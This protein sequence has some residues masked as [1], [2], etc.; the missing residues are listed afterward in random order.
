M[1]KLLKNTFACAITTAGLIQATS[2]HAD[3]NNDQYLGIQAA[4]AN[5]TNH[6]NLS[7]GVS[8]VGTYGVVIPQVH[9][10]FSAELEYTQSVTNPEHNSAASHSEFE[11]YTVA[12][13][14]VMTVPISERISLRGRAGALYENW[15]Y[16]NNLTGTQK[17]SNTDLSIG[18]GAIYKLNADMNLIAEVTIIESD[19]VHASAG[20][21]F[22]L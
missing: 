6:T 7:E 22:N 17:D 9:D 4:I 14:A 13:Y 18:G 5:V 1:N 2:A 15:E 8:V 20:M 3:I 10:Y 12:G 11:Y 19:I 16:R 21:Q